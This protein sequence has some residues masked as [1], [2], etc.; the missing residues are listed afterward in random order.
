[1]KRIAASRTS[2]LTLVA[3]LCACA[4]RLVPDDAAAAADTRP[5]N[6]VVILADDLGWA[7][8]GCYG[9]DLHETPHIDRLARQ[10]TRF[11]SAYAASIC[12]PTRA[13]LLTG[14]HY[15]R[16]HM[17]IWY[18]GSLARERG[19]KLLPPASV[20]NLPLDEVT[21][22][23]RLR[24]AGYLTALVGKWHLGDANHYP[25][26][27]GFDVNIGGTHWGAPQTFFYPYRGDRYYGREPRYVPD[28][29]FG[30]PDE[31][32]TDRLTDEAIAVIDRAGDRPFFLYLSHHAVHTPI[33][34]K[35]QLVEHY[36]RKLSSE[37]HHQNAIY[38]AMT[39]SLDDSV[40]RV[41]DKLDER[42]LTDNTLVIFLSDNGGHVMPFDGKQVT[43]NAPLRSGKGSLYEGGVRV[44]LIVRWPGVTTA[45]DACDEPVCVM[46]L[47]PTIGAAVQPGESKAWSVPDGQSLAPLLKNATATLDRD[48]L[49]FHYPHYYPTTSPVGAIRQRDWKLL[50]YFEDD[51]VELY[52]LKDDQGEAHDLAAKHPKR[53][54]QLRDKLHAWRQQIDAQMPTAGGGE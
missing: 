7:D 9:A 16:L 50:E 36:E 24:E 29:P 41:L 14:K 48:A 11:T 27:Q 42:G 4:I 8:L 34:G 47:V 44:P 38:A 54:K 31:Y 51:R 3:I 43:D 52:N 20:G 28:L 13:A 1:M 32:L 30:T 18:E 5:P 40:G 35:P 6:V 12:S 37:F 2:R 22:A 39:H 33:E 25:E 45:G 46:D 17:T 49:Y 15:A 21:L 26:N 10:G 23:E 53:A 19:H